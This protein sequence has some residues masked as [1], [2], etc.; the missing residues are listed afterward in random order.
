MEMVVFKNIVFDELSEN[1]KKGVL[2]FIN[3]ELLSRS[4]PTAMLN[5]Q[6]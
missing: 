4:I 3:S 5:S 2:S 6:Q 1:C